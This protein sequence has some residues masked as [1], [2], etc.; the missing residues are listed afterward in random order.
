M[1]NWWEYQT[2][3]RQRKTQ[4]ELFRQEVE[5]QLFRAEAKAIQ[6][7]LEQQL[8]AQQEAL[9]FRQEAEEVK[10]ES[11]GGG[12][13]L[14]KL[15][16][17]VSWTFRQLQRPNHA[18]A[19]FADE[20]V[21]LYQGKDAENPFIAA[22]K[23]LVGSRQTTFADVLNTAGVDNKIAR[24]ILGFGLDVLTDPTTYVGFG[25]GRAAS[26]TL[27]DG[28]RVLLNKEGQKIV[29]KAI[30]EA[31]GAADKLG[32]R[33]TEDVARGAVEQALRKTGDLAKYVEKGGV[34]FDFP[35]VGRKYLAE[36]GSAGLAPARVL[37]SVIEELPGVRAVRGEVGRL[38]VSNYRL[39]A[40]GYSD[41]AEELLM[42][43][44]LP[45]AVEKKALSKYEEMFGHLDDAQQRQLFAL[46]EHDFDKMGHL[47]R[48][49]LFQK[50]G[51]APP[52]GATIA[53]L[54]DEGL[55]SAYEM[56]TGEWRPYYDALAKKAGV[57]TLADNYVRA[58][59]PKTFEKQ[60]LGLG[61]LLRGK[62]IGA[63]KRRTIQGTEAQV[64][65]ERIFEFKESALYE[66]K[67]KEMGAA[68]NDFVART[69]ERYGV[70]GEE[71]LQEAGAGLQPGTIVHAADRDNFGT[72]L[73]SMGDT[74]SVHFVSKE[75]T[76]ATVTLP[77]GQLKA[78]GIR[79]GQIATPQ[80]T[81]AFRAG[82]RKSVV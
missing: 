65:A 40:A 33:L 81:V 68:V 32:Q 67:E 73:S 44:R 9:Q 12:G 36:S 62:K 15:G 77:V 18:I 20:A 54:E 70:R 47:E 25:M 64:K 37:G 3:Q 7:P 46:A 75:G 27:A 35:I 14:G 48:A 61:R 16:G 8:A 72:V 74:A 55:K 71:I 58:I 42:L 60:G 57:N 17:G 21:K 10:Q 69:M 66:A 29:Q 56:Y 78:V 52:D 13:F 76:H 5:P 31:G 39:K 24:G 6:A 30:T 49:D 59:Y 4:A 82:D 26:L 51:V 80:G 63:A 43:K 1:T 79:G 53:T 23:G 19:S 22:G 38:F 41:I 45:R 34:H 28:T 50:Y 11:G 2:P